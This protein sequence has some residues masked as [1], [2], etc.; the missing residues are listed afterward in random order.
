MQILLYWWTFCKYWDLL[1]V[2]LF[3]SVPN[4]SSLWP[5]LQFHNP[6]WDVLCLGVFCMWWC[7]FINK[8]GQG[9]LILFIEYRLPWTDY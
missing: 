3:L 2:D 5:Q 9:N 7:M 8:G 6:S 1:K 4:A